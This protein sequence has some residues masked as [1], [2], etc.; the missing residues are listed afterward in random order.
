MVEILDVEVVTVV[1]FC[2]NV[3]V[4]VV[5]SVVDFCLIVVVAKDQ[6]EYNAF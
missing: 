3:E 5:V 6:S 4:I 1:D 2:T